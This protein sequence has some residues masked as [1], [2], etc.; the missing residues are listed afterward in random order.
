[1]KMVVYKDGHK[2]WRWRLVAE[3]GQV[4]GDS[5]EGYFNKSHAVEMARKVSPH[6]ALVIED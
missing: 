6:A 1:M 4:I 3:N 5:A 2:E